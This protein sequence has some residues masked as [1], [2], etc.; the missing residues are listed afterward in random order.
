MRHE[1]VIQGHDLTTHAIRLFG[2]SIIL[3]NGD[4]RSD[5]SDGVPAPFLPGVRG[6]G[7]SMSRFST[8]GDLA[9]TLVSFSPSVR[10]MRC[11]QVEP[12]VLRQE[13]LVLRYTPHVILTKRAQKLTPFS[14]MAPDVLAPL[15][16]AKGEML[17]K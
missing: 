10:R 15:Q 7:S 3:Q 12:E 16:V 14:G 13:A 17:A 4:I 8:D 2:M 9:G 5:L 6:V 1:R 11:S